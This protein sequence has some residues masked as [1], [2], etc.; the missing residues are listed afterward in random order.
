MVLTDSFL[1]F[2]KSSIGY[3]FTDLR[4]DVILV[5][6]VNRSILFKDRKRSFPS[7]RQLFQVKLNSNTVNWRHVIASGDRC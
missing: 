5:C 3:L 2:I 1:L 4:F 6:T 7:H